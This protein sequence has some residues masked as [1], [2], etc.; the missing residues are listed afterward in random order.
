MNMLLSRNPIAA[1][2]VSEAWVFA[3]CQVNEQPSHEAFHLA[4]I[5]DDPLKEILEVHNGIDEF[6]SQDSEKY[7][8]RVGSV[9]NTIFP[10][11]IAKRSKNVEELCTRYRTLY[12]RL[13]RLRINRRGTYFGRLVELHNEHDQFLTMLKK[14]N[15]EHIF[16]ANYELQIYIA[17]RDAKKNRG[18]PC[19]SFCSLQ[20]DHNSLHMMA[21]YRSQ[22]MISRAYGNYLGLGR[23]LWY[24]AMQSNLQVGTLTVIAGRAYIDGSQAS[25]KPLLS[26][27]RTILKI[28][29]VL[30]ETE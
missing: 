6:Y 11:N 1:R 28:E 22:C 23:L 8:Y 24:S 4:V 15:G 16:S 20:R 13:R 18:F 19:L 29:E 10:I 25:I 27:S 17:T 9:S 2:N 14:L 30:H 12:P 5:I 26:N 21:Y 7:K 3:A